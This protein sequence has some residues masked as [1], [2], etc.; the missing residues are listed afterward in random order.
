MSDLT[1][2][3]GQRAAL[4]IT[5]AGL[6]TEAFPMGRHVANQLRQV[7]PDLTDGELAAVTMQ[8]ASMVAK[9]AMNHY[10]THL[11]G[12]ANGLGAVVIDLAHLDVPEA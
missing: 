4:R 11:H 10:C 5:A 7:L 9:E 6:P 1:L 8:I 2:T 3:A 12:L